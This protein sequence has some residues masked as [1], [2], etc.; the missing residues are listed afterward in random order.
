MTYYKLDEK[1]NPVPCEDI[2]EWGLW[3]AD[4]DRSLAAEDI[5]A[6]DVGIYA[7]IC[8]SFLGIDHGGNP[9]KP[10]LWETMI[11]NAGSSEEAIGYLDEYMDRYTSRKA[12]LRGHRRLKALVNAVIK[13]K[14][15]ELE[16]LRPKPL[17]YSK[18]KRII[19][20]KN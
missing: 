10:I 15:E 4:A 7:A 20:I 3:M 2:I 1:D 18:P 6:P 17:V 8:T 5:E 12:A 11:F 19:D 9:G 14:R 13:Q 16:R